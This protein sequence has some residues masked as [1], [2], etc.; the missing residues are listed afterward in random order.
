MI[1]VS[2]FIVFVLSIA[3]LSSLEPQILPLQVLFMVIG[4]M[5]FIIFSLL[6]YQI[7][8]RLYLPLFI[9]ISLFL[10]SGFIFGSR[11][12]ET[13]RWIRI[14]SFTIQPS[15]LV[16]PF[17]ILAFASFVS[18]GTW[19]FRRLLLTLIFLFL[20]AYLVFQ[21]P[22]LGSS[23][24]IVLVWLLI[25]S[26]KVDRKQT[27]F[28]LIFFLSGLFLTWNILR[29]YQ[30]VRIQ[31]FFKPLDDPL[32]KGYHLIQ[33]KITAG[34]GKFSGRGLFHGTQ[35]Y[36][37]FLPERTSDFIFASL[38][39][40]LGFLGCF[41]LLAVYYYV[42]MQILKIADNAQDEFGTL[43]CVG[44]FGLIFSQIVINVGMNLGLMP[45]TG[46]TLPFVSSGGSS[47]VALMTSLGL[48]ESVARRAKKRRLIE[49]K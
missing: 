49:I 35:S 38:A 8:S 12:R 11:T 14:G 45:I 5:V 30:K 34:S 3:V 43:I 10:I 6:D 46:I 40:E 17:L 16:K 4:L 23:L 15:E 9:L 7:F 27:L 47:I 32:G 1:I 13:L 37:K 28:L 29:D 33:A 48:V 21:Q 31:T 18:Q 25:V 24:V 44:V 22:D 42:L 20:P 2:I 41:I 19:R 36:L 39:E 26:F